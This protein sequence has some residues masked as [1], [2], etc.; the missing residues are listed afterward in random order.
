MSRRPVQP[1]GSEADPPSPPPPLARG[2]QQPPTHN[3]PRKTKSKRPWPTKPEARRLSGPPEPRLSLLGLRHLA[4]P[5]RR[6]TR[7]H[8]SWALGKLLYVQENDFPCS[9]PDPD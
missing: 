1:R 9:S 8:R 2:D 4:R 6:L 7:N 5:P 3:P